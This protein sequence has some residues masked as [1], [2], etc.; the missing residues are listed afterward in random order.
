MSYHLV[1]TTTGEVTVCERYNYAV[2]T[3]FKVLEIRDLARRRRKKNL[4]PTYAT[5]GHYATLLTHP[6]TA[7]KKSDA[8]S[9][10]YFARPKS[11]I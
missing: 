3:R 11:C 1:K 2:I 10:L 6:P 4:V 5:W 8:E 9:I 7:A